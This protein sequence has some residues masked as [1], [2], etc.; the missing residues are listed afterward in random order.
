MHFCHY[1]F[2]FCTIQYANPGRIIWQPS[3]YYIVIIVM[4]TDILLPDSQYLI[5]IAQW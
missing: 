5:V 4:V 2:L 1:S 3:D